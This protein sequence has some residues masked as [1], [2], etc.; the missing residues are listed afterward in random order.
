MQLGAADAPLSH[1]AY[2]AR[3]PDSIRRTPDFTARKLCDVPLLCSTERQTLLFS[4]TMPA[5]LSGFISVGLRDPQLIRLDVENK[6]SDKLHSSFFTVAESAKGAVL[7]FL[8]KEVNVAHPPCAVKARM[9]AHTLGPSAARRD[10]AHP[11]HICT[12]TRLSPA[13]SA[14]RLGSPVPTSAPR[15]GSPLPHLHRDSAFPCHICTGAGICRS[16]LGIS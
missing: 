1:T 9:H 7:L 5:Q 12:G 10:W 8:L 6:I 13:T 2:H 3:L 4:A 11:C 16:S 14:P 15:L